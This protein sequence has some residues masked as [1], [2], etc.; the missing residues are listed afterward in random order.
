MSAT[1]SIEK[2]LRV[3]VVGAGEV[4]Q[5]VHLPVLSLL[6]HLYTTTAICDV[7]RKTAQHC[8]SKFHIPFSATNATEVLSHPDVD[9][10]FILTSDEYHEPYTIA[11]LQAGKHVMVEK[12]LTLST[13]SAKRI[14]AAEAASGR[15]VFV[16]YM[17]RY[18]P[19]FEAFKREVA[20]IPRILYARSRDFPGPNPTFVAQSGAFAVRNNDIPAALDKERTERIDAL[21]AEVFSK[22]TP[23]AVTYLLGMPESI[24]GVSVNDPVYSAM[25]NYRGPSGSFAVTYESGWDDVPDFDAHLAIYG[26]TKRV[27]IKYDTPFVKG[28]PIK[29]SVQEKTEQGIQTREIISSY[30]DAY[31]AELQE[32]YECIVNGKPVKTTASDALQDLQIYDMMYRKW[33][34]RDE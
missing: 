31:T 4:A 5:V 18:A 34:K 22:P 20:S 8:A 24:G 21:I 3:G 13:P 15:I 32:L 1:Q 27:T 9:V 11:A 2:R 17:R 14:I 26:Q 19:S 23:E 28:L 12:P 6:S 30:E 7:S 33:L 16:C 10:V 29:V 25:F